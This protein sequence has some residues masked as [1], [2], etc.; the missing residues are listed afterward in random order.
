[1]LSYSLHCELSAS[2][3]R[4]RHRDARKAVKE[5]RNPMTVTTRLV[6]EFAVGKLYSHKSC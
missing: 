3:V 1:M 6:H 4:A 2:E 5:D